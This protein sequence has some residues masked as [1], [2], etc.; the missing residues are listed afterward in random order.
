M[1]APGDDPIR[2]AHPLL[3]SEVYGA[4]DDADRAD[5]H[6]RLAGV[7]S[8]PEEHARHLA[9]GATGSDPDVAEALDAAAVRAHGRGAPDAAAELSELAAGLTAE[10]DPARARRMAASGRYRLLAGDVARAREL[11]ER[12]LEE[13]AATSGSARAELLFRLAGVRMLMDDFSASEELGR[14]ALGEAADDVPLTVRIKLLLAGNSFITARNWTSG[15]QHAFEAMELAEGLDDPRLLAATIG[16]YATWRY[17]TGQGFDPALGR[18]M[19]ELEPWTGQLRTLDLPEFDLANIEFLEGMTASAI[20]RRRSLIERAEG[21]GDYSSLPFLLGN[22]T[23]GDFLEGRM[24]RCLGADRS[25]GAAR[26]GDG[27]AHC[28]GAHADV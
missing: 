20:A 8:E 7:V 4:L 3:A 9:L 22:A 12:A 6:R 26:P 24:R 21:D 17:A 28:R 5:L 1:L 11:L 2:F 10:T 25:R 13:P 16:P 18:R 19:T 14:E 23:V 15:A 27:S